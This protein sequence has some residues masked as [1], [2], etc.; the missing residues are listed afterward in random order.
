[1]SLPLGKILPNSN[2]LV[3]RLLGEGAYGEVYLATHVHLKIP[4]ALKVLLGTLN[5]TGIAEFTKEAQRVA[6]LSLHHQDIV[7][8]IEFFFLPTGEPVMVL[9]LMQG[10]SLEDVVTTQAG[11]PLTIPTII[12]YV[13]P[14][15]RALQ[16][17]HDQGFIHRDVKPANCLLTEKNGRVKLADFGIAVDAK[18]SSSMRAAG[19]IGTIS[20]MAPEQIQKAPTKQSDQYALATI[21]YELLSGDVPFTGTT[22][23][24]II[25]Q[26]H[27]TPPP[28]DLQKLTISAST[29]SV[30]QKALAKKPEARFNRIE[31]FMNALDHS[32]HQAVI[33]PS[34]VVVQPIL[35]SNIQPV[36][37]I[38]KVDTSWI[39][40]IIPRELHVY[41]EA[42]AQPSSPLHPLF[43]QQIR[44]L[45]LQA[46][47]T[48]DFEPVRTAALSLSP[49]V[50]L[51][52]MLGNPRALRG[53]IPIEFGILRAVEPD[54]FFA[55]ND[56][57]HN[58]VLANLQSVYQNTQR[59]EIIPLGYDA[60][61]FL[62]EFELG[63]Y[64]LYY[65]YR[66]FLEALEEEAYQR[67]QLYPKQLAPERQRY[68]DAAMTPVRVQCEFFDD[69]HA[70]LSEGIRTKNWEPVYQ[71]AKKTGSDYRFPQTIY[72][73]PA[74]AG[75]CELAVVILRCANK[76]MFS[77]SYGSFVY[78]HLQK[79]CPTYR[80]TLLDTT[81]LRSLEKTLRTWYQDIPDFVD[82]V[83]VPLIYQ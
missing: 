6:N 47:R 55:G 59:D 14:I 42:L 51:E 12:E 13:R 65:E 2:Y 3:E 5:A 23:E 18:H 80:I 30:L 31:A 43:F 67:S 24:V 34:P 71:H 69:M 83:V 52:Q 82:E 72:N 33:V 68:Y 39:Q 54:L 21:V 10:G 19:A 15:A 17:A 78:T 11:I 7:Q 40:Y 38:Q 70:V 29:E 25:K 76:T 79:F 64:S 32:Q 63:S 45:L 77:S 66:P 50:T 36:Q 44:P 28:L 60:D 62:K 57:K 35:I 9:E 46:F 48:K 37:P 61:A 1:M 4:R 73:F 81:D 41:L 53:I 27:V 56:P 16:Y 49:T 75:I 74:D 8:V 22:S 20:Y 58:K 26:L